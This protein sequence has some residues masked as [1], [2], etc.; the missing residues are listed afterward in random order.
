MPLNVRRISFHLLLVAFLLSCAFCYNKDG[1]CYKS[2]NIVI[3]IDASGSIEVPNWNVEIEF[4]KQIVEANNVSG[5]SNKFAIVDFSTEAKERSPFDADVNKALQALN[6]LKDNHEQGH[7]SIDHGLNAALRLFEANSQSKESM[8][9]LVLISDGYMTF[10]QGKKNE[11]FLQAPKEKLAANNV[12]TFSVG[13]GEYKESVLQYIASQP[14]ATHVVKIT[15]PQRLLAEMQKSAE[16]TCESTVERIKCKTVYIKKA[17]VGC[18]KDNNNPRPLPELLLTDRDGTSPAF[19][20]QHTNWN[21]WDTYMPD[22][23]CRCAEKAA[24][25]KRVVIGIQNYGECWSNE[26]KD[27][28]SR[29][30]PADEASC[31]TLGYANCKQTDVKCAGI[32]MINY[33]YLVDGTV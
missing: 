4:A 24:T 31:K 18:Y 22:F 9:V 33:V 8:N 13:V 23:I 10:R 7:T 32:E 17:G 12:T 20:G 19:S 11:D 26:N 25:R 5:S 3:V 1:K 6:K 2:L 29:D 21:T 30:G 15:E 28:Y 27:V 16:T 14:S